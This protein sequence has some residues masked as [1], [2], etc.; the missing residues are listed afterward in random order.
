M[1]LRDVWNVYEI[2]A[3]SDMSESEKKSFGELLSK[4]YNEKAHPECMCKEKRPYP[5]LHVK[6]SSAG[7]LFL[8]NNPNSNRGDRSHDFQCQFNLSS[9]GY[10]GYLK[11]KGIVIDEDGEITCSLKKRKSLNEKDGEPELSAGFNGSGPRRVTAATGEN[12]LRYLFLTW[13]Q[14][15]RIHEYVPGQQRNLR[16]RLF[17]IMTKTKLDSIKL[18]SDNLYIANTDIRYNFQKHRIIIAWGNKQDFPAMQSTTHS[19]IVNLPVFSLDDRHTRIQDISILKSVYDG[20]TLTRRAVHTGYWVLYRS[21]NE[22]GKLIEMELLFEPADPL[23]GI[24]LESSYEAGMIKFLVAKERHFQKP[25]V[26]NVTELL[27]DLRPDMVLFDTKPKTIIEVAGFQEEQ[28]KM[29]LSKKREV[30]VNMGYHYIEWD[31]NSK[32]DTIA[33]PHRS[34]E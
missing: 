6:K 5:R 12:A 31:G 8:A 13:L 3:I 17:R 14:E 26:G 4:W 18:V 34:K 25:L 19:F 28:Y 7:N 11:E 20:A 30:Y 33:L 1:R 21:E 16:S 10:K 15:A 23:T 32:I 2:K 29:N 27:L 22:N 9:T 24:P